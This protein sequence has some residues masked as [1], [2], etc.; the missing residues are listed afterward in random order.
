MRQYESY[1]CEK[2]GNEI[3]VQEVGGENLRVVEKRWFVPLII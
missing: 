2:C 1:K 3:E